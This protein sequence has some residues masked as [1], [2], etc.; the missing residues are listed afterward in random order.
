MWN[1]V[2]HGFEQ[3]N[4]F[5]L[6]ESNY[7][8]IFD[9]CSSSW[10]YDFPVASIFWLYVWPRY[11][12]ISGFRDLLEP[13]DS[14]IA[15]KGFHTEKYLAEK[16]IALNRPPFMGCNVRFTPKH[17]ALNEEIVSL[18]IHL[19]SFNRRVKENHIFDCVIPL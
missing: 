2:I 10:G 16:G 3:S 7:F 15:N 9:W 18:R 13:G 4:L 12:E 14:V 6:Q 11:C 17:V 5:Q 19:E 1:V 8:Q